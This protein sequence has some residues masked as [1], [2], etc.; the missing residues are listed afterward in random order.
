M[1][2]VHF[3]IKKLITVHNINSVMLI[4]LM[5]FASLPWH[6]TLTVAI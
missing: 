3:V 5:S 6:T 4:L 2:V 1:V